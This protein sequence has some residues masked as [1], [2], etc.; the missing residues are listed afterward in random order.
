MYGTVHLLRSQ[1]VHT[2]V[3]ATV[4]QQ[5]TTCRVRGT[6]VS[7]HTTHTSAYLQRALLA[8][9]W[10]RRPS[11][12]VVIAVLMQL[13][14]PPPGRRVL[15][16]KRVASVRVSCRLESGGRV[17][18]ERQQQGR[19]QASHLCEQSADCQSQ[20]RQ[21]RHFEHRQRFSHTHARQRV[22]CRKENKTRHCAVWAG[23]GMSAQRRHK[24]AYLQPKKRR[25]RCRLR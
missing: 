25:R 12:G 4:V 23:A 5:G 22:P 16:H 8:L 21:T 24:S 20:V 3:D 1:C 10:R 14:Q 13:V 15:R 17:Q 9:R 6:G 19:V 7:G 11:V 18:R 2:H